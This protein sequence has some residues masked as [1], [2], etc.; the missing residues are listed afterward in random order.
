MPHIVISDPHHREAKRSGMNFTEQY[1]G[2]LVSDAPD[3]LA[4][5]ATTKITMR[6]MYGPEEA[7]DQVLP[8]ATFTLREGPNVIGYEENGQGSPRPGQREPKQGL[9][10]VSAN[11]V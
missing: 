2:I 8:G 10:S 5:G 3:E 9:R 11:G 1:L 6:L 7:Y 4:P